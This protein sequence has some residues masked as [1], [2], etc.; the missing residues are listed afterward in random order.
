MRW[1]ASG[2]TLLLVAA[3][4]ARPASACSGPCSWPR[5]LT[6]TTGEVSAGGTLLI[7][8]L[9][10]HAEPAPF[11][12]V[13]ASGQVHPGS[14]EVVAV[15]AEAEW[16]VV[17]SPARYLRWKPAQPLAAGRYRLRP[18]RAD[19]Y[20]DE[21]TADVEWTVPATAP[22][23]GPISASVELSAETAGLGKAFECTD[24]CDPR[25]AYT[26]RGRIPTIWIT[27]Q[28]M[29]SDPRFASHLVRM[30]AKAPQ[31]DVYAGWTTLTALRSE[32]RDFTEGEKLRFHE[33]ASEYCVELELF[34]IVSD[35]RERI[36]RSC[37]P[38]TL[39]ELRSVATYD[40]C[41]SMRA[42]GDYDVAF[43]E[44]NRAE[45]LASSATEACK[46]W[47]GLCG[48]RSPPDAG[49]REPDA[50]ADIPTEPAAARDAG[51]AADRDAGAPPRGEPA[52]DDG[53]CDCQLAA[54]RR[55]RAVPPLAL[56][57]LLLGLPLLRSR[58]RQAPRAHDQPR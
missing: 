4:P 44:D 48:Q 45:C 26:R 37:V 32:D 21:R 40:H 46:G 1:L 13:D 10:C 43:C 31:G 19:A 3:V 38:D 50:G 57:V 14:V 53:S 20:C 30:V 34:D 12:A 11:E 23:P 29:A 25:Y 5:V 27:P 56:L 33:R 47:Q 17:A 51:R 9:D 49:M 41:T 22:Q 6:T 35:R 58:R 39:G 24:L 2:L 7:S 28:L 15:G 42:Q 8:C 36:G 18:V 52:P 55:Q 54:G 16:I